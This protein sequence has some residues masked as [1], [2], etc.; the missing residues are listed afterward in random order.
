M[1]ISDLKNRTPKCIKG[2]KTEV[3]KIELPSKWNTGDDFV[4]RR[5][6]CQCEKS[7]LILKSSF[8]R[9]KKGLFKKREK[10]EFLAPILVHCRNCGFE[11]VIFD[12]RIHG[13]NGEFGDNS[14]RI[15]DNKPILISDKMGEIYVNYSFQGMQNYLDLMEDGIQYVED[16]FD[17]FQVYFLA[18]GKTQLNQ[19]VSY[20]CT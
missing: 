5:L 14:S 7:D 8:I 11:Q 4:T 17:T 15:G 18:E 16:Y 12:P 20:E 13:Y 2:L 10:M 19:I 1:T 6:F 3:V 9:I